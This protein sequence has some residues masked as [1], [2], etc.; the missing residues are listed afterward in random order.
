MDI[1]LSSFGE[2]WPDFLRDTLNVRNEQAHVPDA[3]Y[4]PGHAK[5]LKMLLDRPRIF[6]TDFFHER[7]EQSAR[8][9]IERLL[10]SDGYPR[11]I[12]ERD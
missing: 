8:R 10:A 4:Y 12:Y 1:D 9:N 2:D 11:E 7:Y 6:Y 5:F 3:I